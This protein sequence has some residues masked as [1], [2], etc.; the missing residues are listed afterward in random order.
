MRTTFGRYLPLIGAACGIL[1]PCALGSTLLVPSQYATIQAGIDAAVAGDTVLVADGTYTGAG[2]KDLDFHGK[3]ITVRSASADPATC[4]IDCEGSGRGFYFHNGE[5]SASV[6]AGFTIRNG[7]VT[8]GSAGG[9]RGGAFSCSSSTSPRLTNCTISG[10]MASQGGAIDCFYSNPTLTDCAITA[11]LAFSGGAVY[12]S[13]SSPA[14]TRCVVRANIATTHAGGALYLT[15]QSSPTLTNCTIGGNKA[16]DYAGA[17][18]CYL[19]NPKLTNCTINGNTAYFRGG[20]VYCDSSTPE[21]AN[22]ILWGDTPQEI[23]MHSSTPLVTYCDVQGGF[24]GTGN[25]SL[26][27]GFAFADDFHLMPSSPCVDAGTNTPTASLPAQDADGNPRPLDGNSD[28]QAVADMGAYEVNPIVPAIGL[29]PA[30]IEFHL[31]EGQ[32]DPA[33]HTLS[34]R[35]AGAGTL[36]WA[37]SW[38]AAWLQAD[39][40][41]GE[42]TAEVDT[43]TLTADASGLSHGAYLAIVTLSDPQASNDPR[44]VEVLLYMNKTLYVPGEYATIQGAIDAAVPADEVLVADGVYTG[45][46]NRNLDFHGKAITL[47]SASGDPATCIID[48]EGSGRGFYF[49]SA[50]TAAAIVTALTIRNGSVADSSPG[51]ACGGAVYCTCASSPTLVDCTIVG[52][53]A[54]SATFSGGGGAVYCSGANPTLIGCTISGN[55]AS[56]NGGGVYCRYSRPTLT[57]CAMSRNTVGSASMAVFT[58]GGGVMCEYSRP[59][60]TDCAISGNRALSKSSASGGGVGSVGS[61]PTLTNCTIVGNR[62]TSRGGALYCTGSPTLANCTIA[63]NAASSGGAVYCLS[64]SSNPTLTNSILWGDTPQEIYLYSGTPVVTYCDVRG[65][66]AGMGNTNAPPLFSR[67]PSDGG[68]GWGDDPTTPN[69]DEGA[70]DDYGDLRLTAGSPCIDAGDNSAVPAGVV[71]DLAGNPRFVDDPYQADTGNPGDP[72]RPVVDMG[73]YEVPFLRG[74]ANCD[75]VVDLDD[76]NPFVTALVSQASYEARYPGCPWLN[77]DTN[78]DGSV[79]FDDINP[80]V[81]CLVASGCP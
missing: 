5:T 76:I 7:N 23:Y 70:N 43:V 61:S 19:S 33:T 1:T 63:G 34:I 35:N 46:G 62:A 56:V 65:G 9:A 32:I 40:V 44:T 80:F 67:S 24:A 3:A 77:G 27:P 6:V 39:R 2:N 13:N 71:T 45:A 17:V 79:D 21:L 31:A 73:A 29:D 72:P 64:G 8:S 25:V 53:T 16:F 37:L 11:N 14:L 54:S 10:N 81:K 75:G 38:E 74:D 18:Y 47:R 58:Y 15:G 57:R 12:C 36:S 78:G 22:C 4:I 51:A 69:I 68:D 30:R 26:D 42:S 49:H 60:L 52:N 41:Q 66:Y 20:A 50:E 55:T 48:C 28:G 59:R